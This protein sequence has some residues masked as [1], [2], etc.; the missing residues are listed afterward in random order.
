MCRIPQNFLKVFR[1]V[2]KSAPRRTSAVLLLTTTAVLLLQARCCCLRTLIPSLSFLL[3][4]PYKT[5]DPSNNNNNNNKLNNLLQDLKTWDTPEILIDCGD[6][7]G[8]LNLCDYIGGDCLAERGT[9]LYLPERFT[10]SKSKRDDLVNWLRLSASEAGFA[11]ISGGWRE[12]ELKLNLMCQRGR[13]HRPRQGKKTDKTTTIRPL[14]SKHRCTFHLPIAWDHDANRF[15]CQAGWGNREHCHHYPKEPVEVR[16][17]FAYESKDEKQ[18][19]ID[20]YGS[21]ASS[22]VVRN[23]LY[24]RTGNVVA[25]STLDY[26]RRLSAKARANHVS[27]ALDEDPQNDNQSLTQAEELL[28]LLT[29]DPTI[30]V[31]ALYS[32]PETNLVTVPRHGYSASRAKD[33]NK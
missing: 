14:E 10:N 6:G 17:G 32:D 16:R 7:R 11:L 31:Y 28:R 13:V 3:H 23:L 9:K 15:Y 1:K 5:M 30:S 4:R 18:L 33:G 22:D 8:I 26:M 19:A 2:G 20:L 27:I 29:A 25:D 21:S 24:K 12:G